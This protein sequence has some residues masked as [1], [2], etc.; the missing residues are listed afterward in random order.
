MALAWVLYLG[1]SLSFGAIAFNEA[2]LLNVLMTPLSVLGLALVLACI[3]ALAAP[4]WRPA[5]LMVCGLVT[6]GRMAAAVGLWRGRSWGMHLVS[7]FSPL[8]R[9]CC[10]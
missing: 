6:R 1:A 7:R 2:F 3:D 4:P 8:R 10:R 5:F 9:S